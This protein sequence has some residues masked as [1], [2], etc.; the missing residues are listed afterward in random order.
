MGVGK[1][2]AGLAE[3]DREDIKAFGRLMVLLS[4]QGSILLARTKGEPKD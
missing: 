1:A 2:A 3:E 4:S